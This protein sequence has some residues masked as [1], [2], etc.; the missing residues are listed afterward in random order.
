MLME[1]TTD[2]V[3]GMYG[4]HASRT[5]TRRIPRVV[6]DVCSV[7]NEGATCATCVRRVQRVRNVCDAQKNHLHMQDARDGVG[8]EE[9]TKRKRPRRLC[10]D[11]ATHPR[12]EGEK[13]RE[14][15]LRVV[16]AVSAGENVDKTL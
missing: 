7:C 9:P 5:S 3:T 2:S 12:E 15:R 16:V 8:Q 4:R 11:D 6:C 13:P 14:L 1:C 10:G